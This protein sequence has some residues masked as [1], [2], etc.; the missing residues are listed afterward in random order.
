MYWLRSLFH[1]TCKEDLELLIRIYDGVSGELSVLKPEAEDDDVLFKVKWMK[2]PFKALLPLEVVFPHKL[3]VRLVGPQ[4]VIAVSAKLKKINTETFV[5]DNKVLLLKWAEA[6]DDTV[7]EEMG[8]SND[9]AM[10]IT[11]PDE[12]LTMHDLLLAA[13]L[14]KHATHVLI[15]DHGIVATNW[16]CCYLSWIPSNSEGSSG[17]ALM[18]D[19]DDGLNATKGFNYMKECFAAWKASGYQGHLSDHCTAHSDHFDK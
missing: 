1:I 14:S 4:T 17:G 3:I 9:L 10:L 8:R 7:S 11:F 2:S 18:F 19:K 15:G 13:R 12:H 5:H 16:K 6:I